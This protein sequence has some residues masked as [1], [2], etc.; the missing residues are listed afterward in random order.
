MS[1]GQAFFFLVHVLDENFFFIGRL[2]GA[3]FQNNSSKDQY[4]SG[5]FLK[6]PDENKN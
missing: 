1:S 6:I 2:S 3:S 5:P 4:N